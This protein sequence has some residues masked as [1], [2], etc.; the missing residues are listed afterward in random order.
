VRRLETLGIDY[1][2]VP[3]VSSFTA[4]PRRPRELTLPEPQ[5]ASHARGVDPMPPR[6]RLEE[7][8]RH[9]STL[10][11]LEHHAAARGR[12]AV[13]AYG[14]D[15]PVAIAPRELARP[16]DRQRDAADI[17]ARPRSEDSLSPDSRRRVLTATE[18]ADSKLYDPSFSHGYRRACS[19]EAPLRPK[20]RRPRKREACRR[21]T[22]AGKGD[23]RALDGV[24]PLGHGLRVTAGSSSRANGNRERLFAEKV[25]ELRFHVMASASPDSTICRATRQQLGRPGPAREEIPSGE[26]DLV[27]DELT[28]AFHY[29]FVPLAE[30][31]GAPSSGRRTF[32]WWSP[33]GTP[34]KSSSRSQTRWSKYHRHRSQR[35]RLMANRHDP[36]RCSKAER[37]RQTTT[38]IAVARALRARGFEVAPSSVAGLPRTH[39]PR[40]RH[41]PSQNLDGWMMGATRCVTPCH[42]PRVAPT[43]AHRSVMGLLGE[44]AT[45]GRL[46]CRDREVVGR[47]VV[48]VV[49]A[50][51]G[52]MSR[53]R[54]RLRVVRYG[55]EARRRGLQPGRQPWTPRPAAQGPG[56]ERD[57]RRNLPRDAEHAF[58][59]TA[60]GLV[61][62][63]DETLPLRCSITGAT[64]ASG[65]TRPNPVA[66]V[67][68]NRPA[69]RTSCPCVS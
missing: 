60:S 13:P 17:R 42:T 37:R 66:R 29:D 32:T 27:A 41:R 68:P 56:A 69:G 8:A 4:A 23:Y 39:L 7:L 65:S 14:A 38:T 31:L 18:F 30:V 45:S 16:E 44:S 51:H 24:S 1:E 6:E 57:A 47:P 54:A 10:C 19:N 67:R 11:S 34:R 36:R 2:I 12:G 50:G 35:Q 25:P 5:T 28:Y 53:R 63:N 26:R 33:E 58:S 46:D 20:P 43:R 64:A 3:G 21:H 40:A 52:T 62:A 61:T 49:D 15:C 48:L 55:A 22:G 9:Q 59:R